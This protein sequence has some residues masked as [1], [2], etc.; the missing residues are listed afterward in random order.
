MI[1]TKKHFCFVSM[2]RRELF[3][4]DIVAIGEMLIDFTPCGTDQA[5]DLIFARKPGG[6]PANVLVANAKL[7]GS[8]AFIGKVGDDAFGHFLESVLKKHRIRTDGLVF[9]R[10]IPTTL[11][12]VTLD[13]A[14]ERSFTF[15]RKPGAD[16]QLFRDEVSLPLIDECRILHFGSVSLTDEPS[17]SATLAAVQY[18]RSAGRLIS[19]DPNYR[20]FLWPDEKSAITEMEKGLSL[21][22]IVKVSEEE[23][24]LL[25]GTSD[26]ELGTKKLMSWGPSLIFVSRGGN[27]S[28]VRAR[29]LC[30]S[31]PGFSVKTIDTNG[32]GDTFLG[33]VLYQLQGKCRKDLL[34]LTSEELYKILTFANAAGAL[35]TTQSGAIPAMPTHEEIIT[36]L[37][38]QH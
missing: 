23:M 29:D 33:A 22:D 25:T 21:C 32:A 28:F 37:E 31:A 30:V 12:F 16:V 6:A 10:K 17:R 18:A 9:D 36:F 14:G 19:F 5:G 24:F 35:A 15:Y 20:P 13:A 34:S 27:G 11:A 4:F 7:G 2:D 1:F 8:C 38:N 3:M 26:L